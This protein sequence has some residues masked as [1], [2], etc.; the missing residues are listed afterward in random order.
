MDHLLSN[1]FR[2]KKISPTK[3]ALRAALRIVDKAR[4]KNWWTL[5]IPNPVICLNFL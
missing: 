5:K 3:F 4:S 1:F 2:L